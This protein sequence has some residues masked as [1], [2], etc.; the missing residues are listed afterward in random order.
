MSDE[1]KD[2][3]N[4]F[5]ELI[6]E[7]LNAILFLFIGFELL[8]I[9]RILDY[10]WVGTLAIGVVLLARLLSIWIPTLM[11]RFKRKFDSATIKILVWGGLRGGVSIALAL[12]IGES[13]HRPL[14][15]AITYFV[16]VFS[17]IVQGLTIGKLAN[18]LLQGSE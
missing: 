7:I 12:S 17:I 15:I 10:W 4:K 2:Y 14:I 18:K 6:D 13:E 16:V 9:P 3:L 11:V 5:W 1:T 8:L